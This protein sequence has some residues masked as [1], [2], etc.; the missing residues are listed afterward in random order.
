MLDAP[1]TTGP[2]TDIAGRVGGAV[3][4]GRSSHATVSITTVRESRTVGL[5]TRLREIS[6]VDS[7]KG[8]AGCRVATPFDRRSIFEHAALCE[9]GYNLWTSPSRRGPGVAQPRGVVA[10]HRVCGSLTNGGGRS[11]VR[12]SRHRGP[13]RAQRALSS[14]NRR[15]TKTAITFMG[16]IIAATAV[17]ATLCSAHATVPSQD[18]GDVARE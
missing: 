1:L 16:V 8:R 2:V 15:W 6:K 7:R 10:D 12:L 11:G 5:T 14:Y 17:V 18:R 3:G 4:A 13:Q 9:N